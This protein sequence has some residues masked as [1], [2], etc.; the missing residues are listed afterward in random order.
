MAL[1]PDDIVSYEFKQALRGYAISEVDDLLDRLADQVERDERDRDEL[2]QRLRDTEARLASAL[3][4]ESMLKRTLITAQQAADRSMADAREQ[5][6]EL[7]VASEREVMEQL[8]QANA[9]ADR[10]VAE[11]HQTAQAE[12]D[13]ARRELADLSARLVELRQL[14]EQHRSHMRHYLS[15]QLATLDELAPIPPTS[16]G[17]GATVAD[18]PWEHGDDQPETG[19]SVALDPV[20]VETDEPS[21]AS[22]HD[23]WGEH[24]PAEPW[25]AADTDASAWGSDGTGGTADEPGRLTIRV[26]DESDDIDVR[27]D[28]RVGYGHDRP[29]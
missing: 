16:V 6:D 19:D 26:R 9:E 2:R 15:D 12:L 27:E 13:G 11:A 24:D 17:T 23:R 25:N 18:D 10:I 5:A 28:H 1:N 22:S 7:R 8:R 20:S 21:D 14:N 3:E 29:E 4:T